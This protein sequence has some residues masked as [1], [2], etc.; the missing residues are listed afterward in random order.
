MKKLLFILGLFCFLF[1]PVLAKEK[2]EFGVVISVS[3][4]VKLIRGLKKVEIKKGTIVYFEDHIKTSDESK[5][6]IES[7]K[8]NNVVVQP[9]SKVMLR[10]SLSADKSEG[11]K[12]V[13]LFKGSVRCKLK[14]LK[15]K[16][17]AIKTPS[18]VAGVRGTDFVVSYDPEKDEKAKEESTEK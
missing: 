5:V 11:K 13:F 15:E 3:G 10:D 16:E 7:G 17:F 9:N 1:T 2:K 12:I 18:A 14:N 6:E 4:K 8:K